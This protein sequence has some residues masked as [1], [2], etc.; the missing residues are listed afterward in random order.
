MIEWERWWRRLLG[1][2]G[3]RLRAR[4]PAAVGESDATGAP[5]S[6]EGAAASDEATAQTA[7]QA[8]TD[9]EPVLP[10][11]AAATV[12]APAAEPAAAEPAAAAAEPAPEAAGSQ[13]RELILEQE[14]RSLRAELRRLEL[15]AGQ[16]R[17]LRLRLEE[18][19]RSL[20]EFDPL[21]GLATTRRFNDRLAVAIAQAQR[22]K[23]QLAIARLGVDG[24]PAL[25]ESL[26]SRGVEDLLRAVALTLENAL[27]QAD[28][29]ASLGPPQVF[30]ILLC[31]IKRDADLMVVADKLQLALRSPFN[32]GGREVALS[33]SLGLALFP[34][35]GHDAET[36]IQSADVALERVRSR[37]GDAW[38]VHAPR[39]R[40]AAVRRQARETALRRA[41]AGDALDL[42]W[43]PI[44]Q[45]DGGAIVGMESLLRA[46]LDAGAPAS[47]EAI[48]LAEESTMAVP[49]GQWALRAAC[50]QGRSWQQAGHHGLLVSA[51]VSVRQL[52]HAAVIRLVRGVLEES[53]LAPECLELEIAEGELAHGPEQAVERLAE[54]RRLGVRIGLGRFGTGE[55]RLAHLH[56]YPADSVRI[57]A[58]VVRGAASSRQDEAVISA[59]VAIARSR[60][61][62]VVADGV[63]SEAQRVLLTRW[64]CDRMLGPLLGSPAAVSEAGAL[65]QRQ[66]ATSPPASLA[67]PGAEALM[68]GR[69]APRRPE[70]EGQP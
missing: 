10:P 8:A 48:S 18:E 13:P 69:I 4:R 46:R 6:A 50:R 16:E 19:I 27:R 70:P 59:A 2:L 3:L 57:D 20:A 23:Q 31:G 45:C 25:A 7:A 37:G 11:A 62:L 51:A 58:S 15:E 41:L 60:R 56:R 66:L 61:L 38:D 40:A 32:I 34:D 29:I 21:T 42:V 12:A 43:R 44:V 33:A 52:L 9:A 35:D 26:G 14:V 53:G 68:S 55:S 39:S 65:L 1:V 5:P 30:T 54:L 64:Q 28:T 63:E 24:F 22:S 47:V 67:Q 17:S 49:L 36:L